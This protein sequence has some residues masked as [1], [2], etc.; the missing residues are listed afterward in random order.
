MAHI[1][2]LTFAS[3]LENV[4]IIRISFSKNPFH[5][6]IVFHVSVCSFF[7]YN[8]IRICTSTCKSSRWPVANLLFDYGLFL[9]VSFSVYTIKITEWGLAGG[10]LAIRYFSWWLAL[11]LANFCMNFLFLYLFLCP[12]DGQ[13]SNFCIL[14]ANNC[15]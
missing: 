13:L 15:G 2:C 12:W 8:I 5:M 7:L 3:C 6:E 4:Y 11:S 1:L 10:W 9:L 14:L